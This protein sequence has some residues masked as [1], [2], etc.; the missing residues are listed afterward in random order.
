MTRRRRW[1]LLP[2]AALG[3]GLLVLV[4]LFDWSWLKGS[5]EGLASAALEREFEV[6]DLDVDLSTAP[7]ITLDRVRIANAEWG[8]RPEMLTVAQ[9]RFALE[10]WPLLQGDIRLPFVQVREPDLLLETNQ[11]GLANWKLGEQDQPEPPPAIPIIRDLEI[12]DATIR[13]HA[14]DRAD[15]IVAALEMVAGALG[16]SSPGVQLSARGTLERQPLSLTLTAAPLAQ[17]EAAAERYPFRLGGR[18][19]ASHLTITGSA[20]QPLQADGLSVEIVLASEEPAPLLALAG[21]E[22]REVGAL[23]LNLMLTGQDQVWSVRQMDARLGATDLRGSIWFDRKGE[24]PAVAARLHS[25][26]VRLVD[27]RGVIELMRGGSGKAAKEPRIGAAL[28]DA[29]AGPEAQRE[30]ALDPD[31]GFG[32]SRAMLPAIDAEVSYTVGRLSGPELAL[33]EVALYGRLHDRLPQI[34]LS[35]AGSHRNEPITLDVALG[36]ATASGGEPYPIRIDVAAA[37]TRI[38]AEGALAR[39]ADL[40]G[41]QLGFDVASRDLDQL[42]ALADVASPP[43]PPFKLQGRLAQDGAVWQLTDLDGR[44]GQSDIHGRVAVD[45]DRP[46]PRITADLTSDQVRLEDLEPLLPGRTARAG[47]A[48]PEAAIDRALAEAR[49][50]LEGPGAGPSERAGFR[51]DRDLLPRVDA[52]ISYAVSSLLGPQL[53]LSDLYLSGRLEDGLPR[54][55]LVGGGQYRNTP[56]EV[57]VQVGRPAGAAPD[58]RAYPIDA[59]IEAADSEIRV[60]GEIGKPDTLGGLDL[61][62]QMASENIN[63]VLALADL[64]LPQIPPFL[65][66]GHVIQN[67][68]VWRIA[69]F[70]GQ[71]S[72]SELAGAIE[73]DLSGKRP[74]I[75]A[76]LQS[77]RLLVSDLL[78]AGDQAEAIAER[79]DETPPDAE[80]EGED[81]AVVSAEGVNLD[82]L[83]EIDADVTFQGEFVEVAEFRFDQLSFDL[84][85]RDEIA[86]LDASGDGKFRDGPVSFEAHAGTEASLENPDARYPIDLKMDSEASKVAVNGTV[87]EPGQLAGLQVDVALEGPNLDRLGEILQL[88]LPTT[89]PFELQS[90]LTRDDDRWHL[91]GLNGTIGDSDIQGRATVVLGGERPTIEAELTSQKLDFDDLGLLVGVPANGEET[92]SV[93]QQRQAAIAAAEPGVLP[94]EPFGV[95]ELGALDARVSYRAERVQAPKLPLEGVV[96][97]LTLED[98]QLTLE[99]LRFDLAGGHLDSVI[100]LDSR[101]DA[102][103]GDLDLKVR[104]IRLNQLLSEFDIEIAEVEMETE[105][106]GTFGG[107]AQLAVRGNSIQQITASADGSI[108]MIMDGGQINA[109]IVEAIGLD[110]GEAVA[111]LLTGDE[112][113]QSE[114]VPIQCFI[115]RFDVQ[116]GVMQTEALVLETSDS[117]ITGKGRIDLGEEILALELLAHPKDQSILSAS[118]PVRIEGTFE[119]PEVDLV[120]QELEEKGLAALAL[121]AVLPVIGAILPFF[122]EGETQDSNCTRLIANARAAMPAAS[123]S[124]NAN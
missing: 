60:Q 121:G 18:L 90:H 4:V 105:G 42:L 84:Q 41:L 117:T 47:G 116:D 46:E 21:L 76:D 32:G 91:S 68:Q 75:M 56:V 70:Y 104:N 69:D 38:R 57:D 48:E 73:V 95:P 120:S 23:E 94:D 25:D 5:I 9:V 26:Q 15:D 30:G 85:L 27:L 16:E 93:A 22:P 62:V 12:V 28:A 1:I 19:G 124:T 51:L 118:T 103:A 107:G 123:P 17:L 33:Q 44:L 102:L 8:S 122:E 45:L 7:T 66:S 2:L 40:G 108:A 13:Y 99:P 58:E 43:I 98:G 80:A 101:G 64:S 119:N 92:L 79:I 49:S 10:L 61:E 54:L 14:P 65:I 110:I 115:G 100:R 83:P 114:M 29:R 87:A 36:D 112:E 55:E 39:P 72:E 89:P 50:V 78:T 24:E 106:V 6:A 63:Q 111:L 53:A 11:E 77:S 82:A 20:E 52:E 31:P 96:L 97:D 59:L 109:L 81:Q 86:V 113:A 34:S 74:F 35:G 37:G 3:A 67:G 71:F 88:S